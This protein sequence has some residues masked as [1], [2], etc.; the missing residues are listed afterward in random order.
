[1]STS[2]FDEWVDLGATW[3]A[4]G[5]SARNSDAF[6]RLRQRVRRRTVWRALTIASEI[7][8]TVAIVGWAFRQHP[9]GETRALV[10]R[11]ATVAFSALVWAFGL[12]NR[13]NG[14]RVLGESSANFVRLSQTR[15]AEARRSIVAVRVTLGIALLGVAPWVAARAMRGEL[16][17]EEW[18]SWGA[19]AIYLVV[20]FAWCAASARWADREE[21]VLREIEEEL[22]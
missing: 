11:S 22:A 15:I 16:Q 12:W 17:R 3:R 20:M 8:L 6:D 1:M 4:D 21:I 18:M 9:G 2:Q 19:F 10:I 13:R 5:A 14:W 7:V